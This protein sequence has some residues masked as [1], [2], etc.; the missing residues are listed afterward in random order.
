MGE[1]M[2]V[3]AFL[4]MQFN[5]WEEYLPSPKFMQYKHSD[6]G[7]EQG[8]RRARA[9]LIFS[10]WIIEDREESNRHIKV[11]IESFSPSILFLDRKKVA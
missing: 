3:A 1:E 5:L 7:P 6:K 8:T 4:S 2:L 11:K 9:W 10:T